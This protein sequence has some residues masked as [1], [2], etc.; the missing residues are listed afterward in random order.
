MTQA[1]EH[2]ANLRANLPVFI[3][4]FE[5]L[6]YLR[7]TV[8][9]FADNGFSNVTVLEQGSNFA[10]L[11]DYLASPAFRAKARLQPLRANIGPRRAVKR[12]AHAA[13]AGQAFIFT[14]PDLDLP[15]PIAPDF[16]TWLFALGARYRVAKVG[17]APDIPDAQKIDLHRKFGTSQ[18]IRGYFRRFFANKLVARVF[19]TNVDTTFFLHVP[20]P[21]LP[22][23]GI[24]TSQTQ[25]PP[26]RVSGPGFLTGHRPWYF[27]N[28]LSE[29]EESHYR[30]RATVASTHF[31]R[32]QE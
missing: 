2:E 9:W 21:H 5:Q 17:L 3:N 32:D 30:A 28:G 10:P 13:G 4:S 18:T 12:A 22:D 11:S 25:I 8:D 15:N 14:D 16:L 20:Q 27:E 6:T 29:A 26:I 31:G 23:F 19:G 1:P 24:L 7:G